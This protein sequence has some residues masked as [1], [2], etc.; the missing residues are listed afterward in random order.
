M[1]MK[2]AESNH[3]RDAQLAKHSERIDRMEILFNCLDNQLSYLARCVEVC[4]EVGSSTTAIASTFTTL[5]DQV[6]TTAQTVTQRLDNM[7]E[8]IRDTFVDLKVDVLT[9]TLTSMENT[10]AS[11]FTAVDVALAQL[12]SPLRWAGASDWPHSP[13][14]PDFPAPPDADTDRPGLARPTGNNNAPT[15]NRFQATTTFSPGSLFPAGNRVSHMREADNPDEDI[16]HGTWRTQDRADT[17][18]HTPSQPRAALPATSSSHFWEGKP[19]Q[20]PT[21]QN[22]GDDEDVGRFPNQFHHNRVPGPRDM[23]MDMH[24]AH[25]WLFDNREDDG[26]EG[27]YVVMGG[28]IK[29]PSNIERF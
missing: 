16:E 24:R 5:R 27:G 21:Q 9:V 19:S 11:R 3:M 28:P 17:G 22:P 25:S 29:S 10:I 7:E 14:P 20:A 13:A 1:L 23:R 6:T 4:S 12:A 2:M 18:A 8:T 15:P 26:D